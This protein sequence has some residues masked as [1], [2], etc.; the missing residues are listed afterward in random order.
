MSDALE[1]LLL[2]LYIIYYLVWIVVGIV[3]LT[4]LLARDEDEAEIDWNFNHKNKKIVDAFC[5]E[6]NICP[7]CITGKWGCTSS[8]K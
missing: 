1:F 8:H 7:V 5:K 3:L 4:L 6:N 2:S